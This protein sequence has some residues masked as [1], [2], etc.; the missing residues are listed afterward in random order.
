MLSNQLREFNMKLN[1]ATLSSTGVK[2]LDNA[3][4]KNLDLAIRYF[5]AKSRE[6]RDKTYKEF[7]E[8][9]SVIYIDI[10]KLKHD[11]QDYEDK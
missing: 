9:L 1:E 11:L 10:R 6:S 5:R 8:R 2:A 4:L 7:D 3:M